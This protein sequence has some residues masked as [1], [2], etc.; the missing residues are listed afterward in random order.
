VDYTTTYDLGSTAATTTDTGVIAAFM[1]FFGGMWLFSMVL[2]VFFLVC[3]WKIFVKAGKPGWAAIVPIYNVIV[4]LEII[5]R[6]TW[7]IV[8]MFVPLAQ[9]YVA[10]MVALD[11]A[12]VFGKS[13]GFGVA[14]IF[15]PYVTYPM[16]AFGKAV[17]T[18]PTKTE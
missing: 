16:L 2:G 8:L 10:I 17:Y 9:L 5:G 12:K 14:N 13:S 3:M 6:P 15:F 18:A 7:W 11:L 4:M 1:A